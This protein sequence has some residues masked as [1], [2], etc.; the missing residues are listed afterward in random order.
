MLSWKRLLKVLSHSQTVDCYAEKERREGGKKGSRNKKAA[1]LYMDIKCSQGRVSSTQQEPKCA[2]VTDGDKATRSVQICSHI[3]RIS[4]DGK[5]KNRLTV[6]APPS[7][8]AEGLLFLHGL[9]SNPGSSLQTEEEAG[10]P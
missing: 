2:V 4:L 10:L 1:A 5:R 6:V 9:E 8:R 7:S 3:Y